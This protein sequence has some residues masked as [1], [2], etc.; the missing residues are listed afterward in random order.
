MSLLASRIASAVAWYKRAG[1]QYNH[2]LVSCGCTGTQ[3]KHR[4]RARYRPLLRP[5]TNGCAMSVPKAAQQARSLI[6]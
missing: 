5:G 6:P 4:L 3:Y 1:A 2:A